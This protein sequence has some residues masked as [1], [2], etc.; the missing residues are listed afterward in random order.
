MKQIK[1]WTVYPILLGLMFILSSS[2]AVDK[3]TERIQKAVMVFGD[4]SNLKETIPIKMLEQAQGI[5]I[6]PKMINAGFGIG[7]KRGKGVAMAKLSSG[8]WSNPVFV[9]ITGGSIG[10]QAGVQ[11]VDLVL[12]FKHKEALTQAKNGD[13]TIGGDLSAA[14]GP[15]GRSASANTDYKLDAEVYSYSRSKG[16]F[17]GISV[18]GSN[19]AFDKTAN[20]NF[21]GS[22]ANTQRLFESVE[23]ASKDVKALKN[24]LSAK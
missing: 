1:A 2:N 9:T 6:I 4:F 13:F 24:A 23:H 22:E 8:E 20:S 5:V 7:G 10:F 16:L 17:A 18:N 11:A 19:I 12:L 3:E 15:V 14:A 21:Y